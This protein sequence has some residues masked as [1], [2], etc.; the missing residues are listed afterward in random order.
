MPAIYTKPRY[1][2]PETVTA[3]EIGNKGTVLNGTLR[4]SIAGFINNIKNLQTQ[5]VSLQ[6]G[7]AQNLVNADKAKIKG[8][9]FEATWQMFPEMLPGFVLK[10][11]GSYLDAKYTSFPDGSGFDPTTGLFF[12][13]R[14]EERRGGNACVSTCRTRWSPY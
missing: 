6:S 2:K 4:Y 5:I 7:G 14:S 9:D 12:G 3:Y 13:Q 10:L 11:A 1:V 8:V